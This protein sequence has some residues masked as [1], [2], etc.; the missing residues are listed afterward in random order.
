MTNIMVRPDYFLV[1]KRNFP[2]SF[3]ETFILPQTAWSWY[4]VIYSTNMD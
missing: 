4:P 3:L 1:E 2:E